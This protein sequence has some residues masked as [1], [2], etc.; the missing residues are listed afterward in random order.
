VNVLQIGNSRC[1]SIGGV[2]ICLGYTC[3]DEKLRSAGF[4]KWE[5]AD[6]GDWLKW[7][8]KS[9]PDKSRANVQVRMEGRAN[10]RYPLLF[11]D[12]LRAF[13]MVAQAYAQV[14]MALAKHHP[15]EDM[16]AYYDIKDPVCDIII[17][18][19]ELWAAATGWEVGSSDS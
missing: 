4:E 7:T 14:K 2:S 11:R 9:P 16:E 15:E 6:P 13:P 18:G 5:K 8:F 12:Y 19:A 3:G 10:Q 1:R 17:G